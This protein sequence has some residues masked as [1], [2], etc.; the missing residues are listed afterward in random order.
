M[1]KIRFGFVIIEPSLVF[2]LELNGKHYLLQRRAID[3][4]VKSSIRIAKLELTDAV[5]INGEIELQL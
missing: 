1:Q 4:E 5:S 3:C 2:R